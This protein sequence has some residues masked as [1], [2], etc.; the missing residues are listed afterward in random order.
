MQTRY[1]QYPWDLASH[2]GRLL[3]PLRVPLVIACV[4]AGL[5]GWTPEGVGFRLAT[6]AAAQDMTEE[7]EL[8][9]RDCEEVQA[10]GDVGAA[11]G[12][13]FTQ[14]TGALGG[15]LGGE[16]QSSQI[17]KMLQTAFNDRPIMPYSEGQKFTEGFDSVIEAHHLVEKRHIEDLG[18]ALGWSK[19]QI[20][21][22]VGN[23]PSVILDEVE[24]DCFSKQLDWELNKL[25]KKRN[26]GFGYTKD[27]LINAYQQAYR[28]E[29]NWAKAAQDYIEQ[30]WQGLP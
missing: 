18:K 28:N 29:S 22:E 8:H 7:A 12:G 23:A 19:D 24:H 9:E 16:D 15:A 21:Q 5:A 14:A 30:R 13:G 6:P 26:S 17:K 1:T 11:V 10:S 20:D 4:V 2:L 3:P 27:S 25:G